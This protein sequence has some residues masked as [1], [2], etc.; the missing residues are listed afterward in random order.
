MSHFSSH[1]ARTRRN[2]AI[3]AAF[4]SNAPLLIVGAIVIA[5]VL[6]ICMLLAVGCEMVAWPAATSPPVGSARAF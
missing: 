3:S 4:L 6:Q 2:F 1:T 5:F